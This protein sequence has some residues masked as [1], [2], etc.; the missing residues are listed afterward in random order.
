MAIIRFPSVM[1][2]YF[3]FRRR[4]KTLLKDE[5]LI[6]KPLNIMGNSKPVVW[7]T[8]VFHIK[9]T[10]NDVFMSCT[11]GYIIKEFCKMT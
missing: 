1:K 6:T 11:V 9:K 8:S 7:K 5:K 3:F 10:G 2:C 4:I